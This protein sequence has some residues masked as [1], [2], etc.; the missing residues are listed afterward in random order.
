MQAKNERVNN[1]QVQGVLGK[2]YLSS[3]ENPVATYQIRTLDSYLNQLK[4]Y[5]NNHS[6][7]E[8][9]YNLLENTTDSFISNLQ[10]TTEL[11]SNAANGTLNNTDRRAIAN[12]LQGVLDNL[13]QVANTQDSNGE[14]I[15]SGSSSN[16]KP[17][18][19][20]NGVISYQG[21]QSSRQLN[22]NSSAQ[23]PYSDSGYRVFENIKNGNGYFQTSQGNVTNTGTGVID[24]GSINN[25]SQYVADTY[26]IQFVTNGG[27]QLAY[28]VTG[29]N[30]GQVVPALPATVPANAPAFTSGSNIVFNGVEI[31]ISGQPNV[32]DEFTV[33]PSQTQNIFQTMQSLINNL[34][35][36]V[37]S[38]ASMADFQNKLTQDRESLAQAFNHIKDYLSEIGVRSSTL[39]NEK[40]SNSSLQTEVNVISSGLRDVDP[41]EV[42]TLLN[43][44]INSLKVAQL[45]FAKTEGLSLINFIG[46][47]G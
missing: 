19:L 44:E 37:S 1:L 40:D 9:R 27:G 25:L 5:Q 39:S 12:E 17:Y 41:T 45:A 15:F 31:T 2:K 16:I 6:A 43:Q 3:D 34:R 21:N 24:P 20:T 46:T 22:I 42:I 28:T 8:N 35:Q 18:I 23:L 26:T 14:Y 10:R 30:S 29:A 7:L 36:N 4:S 47:G 11:L 38:P 33:Q 32:G 13:V